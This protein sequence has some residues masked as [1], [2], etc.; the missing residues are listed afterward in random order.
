MICGYETDEHVCMFLCYKPRVFNVVLE[1]WIVDKAV[2]KEKE[3]T[4][5]ATTH[6]VIAGLSPSLALDIHQIFGE[7]SSVDTGIGN[8]TY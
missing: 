6:K 4:S 8:N 5:S 1:G 7:A 3:P 2:R